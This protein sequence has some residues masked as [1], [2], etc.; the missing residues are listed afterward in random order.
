MVCQPL[1]L[2]LGILGIVGVIIC[3]GFPDNVKTSNFMEHS[4]AEGAKVGPQMKKSTSGGQC[5]IPFRITLFRVEGIAD[6]VFVRK[7]YAV[8]R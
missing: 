6:S 7:M 3:E 4:K 2:Y 1:V 5:R 8:K